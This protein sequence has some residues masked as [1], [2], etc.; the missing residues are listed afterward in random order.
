A[1]GGGGGR[2]RGIVLE[3]LCRPLR[4]FGP[5]PPTLTAF[6]GGGNGIVSDRSDTPI[7][8]LSSPPVKMLLTFPVQRIS[9]RVLGPARRPDEYFG[10]GHFSTLPPF[11]TSGEGVETDRGQRIRQPLAP[12]FTW[13]RCEP[14]RLLHQRLF[15]HLTQKFL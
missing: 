10:H 3:E 15:H 14:V 6:A 5:P 11:R 8:R 4:P 2:T 13:K 7:G 12:T 1:R 9:E